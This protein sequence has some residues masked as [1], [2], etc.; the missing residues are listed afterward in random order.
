MKTCIGALVLAILPLTASADT[1]DR[2]RRGYVI[3]LIEHSGDTLRTI[4]TYDMADAM[5]RVRC[6]VAKEI[7]SRTSDSAS[8]FTCG[9]VV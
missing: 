5:A 3:E 6:I 9:P 2:E 8:R 1:K 4:A 7:F